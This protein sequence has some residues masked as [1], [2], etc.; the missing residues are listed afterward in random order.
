MNEFTYF[1]QDPRS[2]KCT[3]I[4]DPFQSTKSSTKS[5]SNGIS[6]N[7]RWITSL[8]LDESDNWLACGIGASGLSN[9]VNSSSPSSILNGHVSCVFHSPTQSLSCYL[10]SPGITQALSFTK[11]DQ[12][13]PFILF[14]SK[15]LTVGND[16]YVY[17]WKLN[18]E[19]I[20]RVLSSSRSLLSIA[21][22]ED[23]IVVAGTG[24][25]SFGRSNFNLPVLDF[26][27]QSTNY[28]SIYSRIMFDTFW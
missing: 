9:N 1:I 6:L 2:A 8:C 26:F 13:C 21:H 14:N 20:M 23:M 15:V 7:S 11:E 28:T 5:S 25:N 22:N 17:Y 3:S 27:T 19:L 12:V 24:R 16:P 18:G 10:P 4:L